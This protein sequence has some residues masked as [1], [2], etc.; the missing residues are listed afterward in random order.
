[1]SSEA[2]HIKNYE[3]VTV[4]DLD[5]ADE[6]RLVAE[7]NECTFGWITKDGSPMSVTMSYLRSDDGRLWFTASNQRKRIAAI[8]LDPRVSVTI[9][10]SGTSFESG[11]TVSYKGIAEFHDDKT[12]KDWFCLAM[13]RRLTG[14]DGSVRTVLD[15]GGGEAAAIE[16]AHMLNSSRRAVYSVVTSGRISYDGRK[17]KKAT[18]DARD[19]GNLVWEE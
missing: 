7:Q 1:M 2:E 18:D 15:S 12:T 10:S 6:D 5:P 14:C 4:Y 9:T 16:F 17:L 3:E 19:A 8:R 11:L 13:G